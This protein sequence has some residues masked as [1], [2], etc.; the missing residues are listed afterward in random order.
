M[1]DI[2]LY[3]D[4]ERSAALRHEIPIAIGDPF[5]YAEVGGRAMIMTSSLEAERIAEVRPDAELIEWGDLG[6]YELLES[7]MARDQMILEMISRAVAK[8]GVK[9][10]LVD[11]DF[12]IAVADRLRADGVVL[13]PDYDAFADRRRVKSS[14]EM[15]GIRRA[16]KAAEAGMA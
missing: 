9:A 1:A 8:M 3:S 4:T 5:A 14:A 12:P 10:A 13:T 6:F 2:L 7:G 16:Q 11:P 15:A